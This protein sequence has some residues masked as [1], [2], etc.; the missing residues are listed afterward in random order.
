MF[1]RRSSSGE[2]LHGPAGGACADLRS[3]EY[4]VIGI[5][6]QALQGRDPLPWPGVLT[7]GR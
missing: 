1:S 6:R 4:K 3:K 5:G 7:K 2:K